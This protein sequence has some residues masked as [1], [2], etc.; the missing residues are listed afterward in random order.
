MAFLVFALGWVTQ[1]L[2]NIDQVFIMKIRVDCNGPICV[3]IMAQRIVLL[4]QLFTTKTQKP[5]QVVR[6]ANSRNQ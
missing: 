2:I 3:S 1:P 4:K 6:D 5:V